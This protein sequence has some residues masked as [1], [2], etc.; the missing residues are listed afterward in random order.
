MGEG[1][2]GGWRNGGRKNGTRNAS[3]SLS[4]VEAVVHVSSTALRQTM[5]SARQKP[6]LPFLPFLPSSLPPFS[7]LLQPLN[8][9]NSLRYLFQITWAF[10][11]YE[12]VFYTYL[13]GGF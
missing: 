5:R 6:I 3:V 1:G 4:A 13:F 11:F 2:R 7:L 9:S 10:V 12:I 8:I